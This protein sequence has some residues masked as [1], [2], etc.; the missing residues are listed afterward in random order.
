ML[1]EESELVTVRKLN[2]GEFDKIKRVWLE[3]ISLSMEEV[4]TMYF[5]TDSET[6]A[7]FD[8]GYALT[9][10][11]DILRHASAQMRQSGLENGRDDLFDYRV[12]KAD[13][14]EKKVHAAN[15]GERLPNVVLEEEQK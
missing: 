9:R 12:A 8:E 7:L 13:A 14:Y 3:F 5:S 6:R 4:T 11:M 15:L 1:K 2:P 10:E